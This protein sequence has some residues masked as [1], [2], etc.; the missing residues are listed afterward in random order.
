ML[1]NDQSITGTARAVRDGVKGQIRRRRKGRRERRTT[2][3]GER[4]R[5]KRRTRMIRSA[6]IWKE[7]Q[8]GGR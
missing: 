6:G 7:I 3:R 1:L 2:R 8:R 5:R 4:L